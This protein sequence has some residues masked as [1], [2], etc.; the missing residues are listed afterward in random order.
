MELA[1]SRVLVSAMVLQ[2]DGVLENGGTFTG[3]VH[4]TDLGDSS[5]A[6]HLVQM[7]TKVVVFLDR[8]TDLAGY[9]RVTLFRFAA[10]FS[11]DSWKLVEGPGSNFFLHS[12]FD[13][14]GL[15]RIREA[16]TG[17]G[18][19]GLGGESMGF[20]VTA[21][22]E[23]QSRTAEVT[24]LISKLPT[25]IGD[26]ASEQAVEALWESSP[27]EGVLASGFACQP[28]SNLG[29]RRSSQDPRS[30]T[31]TGSLRAAYLL[32]SS[33]VILECVP[34][35][36]EDSFVQTSLK[37]F[38][39][40]TGFLVQQTILHLHE[41]WSARRSRWWALLTAP[42]LGPTDLGPWRP[43][44]PWHSIEDVMDVF[45]V[46]QE[47]AAELR[48]SPQELSTFQDLKP[49]S[50]CC[51]RRNQP[52]PTALHSWGSALT[53][54]PCGCRPQ[55]LTWERLKRSGLCS[56]ILPMNE[57]DC[58]LAFRYP[59]ASEVAYL[60]GLSP[61]VPLGSHPRLALALVGQMASPLQSA[62]V[63]GALARRM[64]QLGVSFSN[65][66]DKIQALHTQRRMLLHDAE[67]EGFRPATAGSLLSGCPAICFEDHKSILRRACAL[68]YNPAEGLESFAITPSAAWVGP[69]G[70]RPPLTRA[71]QLDASSHGTEG[72]EQ[73]A[74][75][76]PGL[77]KLPGS[78]SS[79]PFPPP[80]GFRPVAPK[81]PVGQG[82]VE[83]VI[84]DP[85]KLPVSAS[86]PHFPRP[87]GFRPV[88]PK[89]PA[90]EGTFEPVLQD[91]CP[92]VPLGF[93]PVP[94]KQLTAEEVPRQVCQ[95]RE[96]AG[97][98]S[99]IPQIPRVEG[100]ALHDADLPKDSLDSAEPSQPA[101]ADT[102]F[103]RFR[104]SPH[105]SLDG[106]KEVTPALAAASAQDVDPAPA[107]VGF[108]ARS[109]PALA[110]A[111]FPQFDPF[112]VYSPQARLDSDSA[113][114]HAL[115]AASGT[116]DLR[117]AG[118]Q[119]PV[120][121]EVPGGGPGPARFGTWFPIQVSSPG[122][123]LHVLK[124]AWGTAPL[125]SYLVCDCHG[126][127]LPLD[128]PV[129]P[130]Q[131]LRLWRPCSPLADSPT[132]LNPSA[133]QVK[134]PAL[135][136]AT[137]LPSADRAASLSLQGV[138]LADDQVAQSLAFIAGS[139]SQVVVLEPLLLLQCHQ[140]DDPEPLRAFAAAIY[141]G[142]SVI[143][144]LPLSEHW[145]TFAWDIP[146]GRFE[147]WDS[148]PIGIM[149]LEV[150]SVHRLWSKV[151][152][153]TSSCF[154]FRQG[155]WRPPAPGL[156]GHFALAD[157]WSYLNA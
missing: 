95:D 149:D 133:F 79:P 157:L 105:F 115:A 15:L 71:L 92:V 41:V 48:L 5:F 142:A 84:A 8:R 148:C 106:F 17:L 147:A 29:D 125:P 64:S 150:S 54:C 39:E 129:C 89:H 69:L 146:H 65:T 120:D 6:G 37:Q 56:V 122:I 21:Q 107:S 30:G 86:S 81:D 34:P 45:N 75:V 151:L 82:T 87:V 25:I 32:Q 18:A 50:E 31:L 26:V 47:E 10:G 53:A 14:K 68:P 140:H 33:A 73:S 51:L 153:L 55:P 134:E 35:A 118:Q 38:A 117:P 19:M 12:A 119:A 93:R 42:Q 11:Q 97:L 130:G 141:R 109:Q 3:V 7:G 13:P 27:G 112:K 116:P 1:D 66:L 102:P 52:L 124:L 136:V 36:M 144:A 28:Y 138:A 16:C 60:S 77:L 76:A 96:R 46:T 57:G 85:S 59:S 135:L 24:S 40:A 70:F 145:V 155:P 63:F 83:P 2:L 49:L 22:N 74:V 123:L 20:K 4:I 101:P 108:A 132:L 114:T 23:I 43:H 78:A 61:R 62:W 100:A 156:C 139:C 113:V 72:V 91:S 126:Q 67:V 99:Q 110:A 143:S 104:S 111:S 80:V 128:A 127:V 44:G 103:P 131:D 121:L 58:S 88:T 90:G 94:L 98:H 154:F 9:C 137:V 152:G